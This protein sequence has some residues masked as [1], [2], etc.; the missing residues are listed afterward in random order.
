MELDKRNIKKI[1]LI[2]TFAILLFVTLERLEAVGAF[3]RGLFR[4]F[5]PVVLGLSMAFIMNTL[6][7][8]LENRV[9]AR[10][11]NKVWS[12]FRAPR[13]P[14]FDPSVDY[15]DRLVRSSSCHT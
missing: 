8:F 12:G 10:V 3:C 5:T 1:L 9:F 11:Q 4:I 15:R 14:R 7:H 2:I 13:M 6:L